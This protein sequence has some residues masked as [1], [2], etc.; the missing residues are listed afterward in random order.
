MAINL[1]NILDDQLNSKQPQPQKQEEAPVVKINWSDIMT[2]WCYRIPK[3]YPTV[4]DGVFTEY[5]EVKVL[6]EILE[7]KF[8]E[9]VPLPAKN[10]MRPTTLLREGATEDNSEV[11]CIYFCCKEVTDPIIEGC[12]T[13]LTNLKKAPG[14]PKKMLVMPS[15]LTAKNLG[16]SGATALQKLLADYNAGKP[17]INEFVN[18]ITSAQYI[19]S[20]YGTPIAANQLDRGPEFDKFKQAAMGLISRTMGID[21]KTEPDKWSP[22]DIFIYNSGAPREIDTLAN[23]SRT[24]IYDI[25]K[26]FTE[27]IT[28]TSGKIVGI[29]LKKSK[30]Q[31]GKALSY[32]KTLNKD[33]FEL[34]SDISVE[35]KE[36]RSC[37]YLSSMSTTQAKSGKKL[38]NN[39]DK[40]GYLAEIA[41][42]RKLGKDPAWAAVTTSAVNTIKKTIANILK[43]YSVSN[44]LDTKVKQAKSKGYQQILDLGDKILKQKSQDT[45]KKFARNLFKSVEDANIV[46]DKSYDASVTAFKASKKRKAMKLCGDAKKNFLAALD[47]QQYTV[48]DITTPEVDN[49]VLR[50]YKKASCYL[51]ATW[52]LTGSKTGGLKMPSGFTAIAKQKDPFVAM[53]AYAIGQ[54]GISPYFIKVKGA[55]DVVSKLNQPASADYM[56]GDGMVETSKD[57]AVLVVDSEN[58]AGFAVEMELEVRKIKGASKKYK[59]T[60]DFRFAGEA[61]N[62]EVSEIH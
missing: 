45:A 43:Q 7:E 50:L 4:V 20:N 59:V 37:L 16:G 33:K 39:S 5:E 62:I 47:S 56:G 34:A 52:F 13:Y 22:A 29:S 17:N 3:G 54:A 38:I 12:K 42:N 40:F 1:D 49:T 23:D 14:K 57:K 18:A 48:K 31:G 58:A 36:E 21:L 51:L 27:S 35:A 15:G 26:L 55:G 46:Y 41:V 24:T 53:T 28:S 8:G 2:E 60:L 10:A 32:R 25:N 19:K 6:N 44:R 61:I 30:A 11:L 9:T